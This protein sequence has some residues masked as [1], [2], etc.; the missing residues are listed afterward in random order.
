MVLHNMLE[1]NWTPF[2]IWK[3]TDF[4]FSSFSTRKNDEKRLVL[5]YGEIFLWGRGPRPVFPNYSARFSSVNQAKNS[6]T[7]V[8]IN[9]RPHK[10]LET[11]YRGLAMN[12]RFRCGF[13]VRFVTVSWPFR[14]STKRSTKRPR[15]PWKTHE[16][17]FVPFAVLNIIY[18]QTGWGP[19]RY[20]FAWFRRL[21]SAFL[22]A[23][24]TLRTWWNKTFKIS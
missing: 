16:T 9:P 5:Q 18:S 22:G 3:K 1:E 12:W 23:G 17:G 19:F 6:Q 21:G 8:Q 7:I 24:K 15:K 2:I 11:N 13:V 4:T 20:S 14:R 10:I